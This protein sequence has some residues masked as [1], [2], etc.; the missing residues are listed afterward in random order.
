VISIDEEFLSKHMQSWSYI[1]IQAA[2]MQTEGYQNVVRQRESIGD[3]ETYSP[4]YNFINHAKID[5]INYSLQHGLT[6]EAEYVGWID[7]GYLRNE[8]EYFP[9]FKINS[10]ALFNDRINLMTNRTIPPPLVTPEGVRYYNATDILK[11]AP[12]MILGGFWFGSRAALLRYYELY[13]ACL[14]QLHAHNIADDDQHV[15]LCAFYTEPDLFYIWEQPV[16]LGMAD[17]GPYAL[18][19]LFDEGW[20]P[21]TSVVRTFIAANMEAQDRMSA[22]EAQSYISPSP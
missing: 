13:H 15:Q 16:V 10:Y 11:T 12:F 19:V 18:L 2:I 7:F 6:G 5:F 20:L 1:P 22:A 4:E 14:Q 17:I 21:K 8:S 3:P 9:D